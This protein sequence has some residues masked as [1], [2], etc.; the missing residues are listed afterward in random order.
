MHEPYLGLRYPASDIPAQ[1]RRLYL[2]NWLRL[3]FDAD[4]SQRGSF[5]LCDPTQERHSTS[6]S[7][8]FEASRRFTSST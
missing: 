4:R 1:S 3:I 8:S 2:Q 7:R 6:A 5:R